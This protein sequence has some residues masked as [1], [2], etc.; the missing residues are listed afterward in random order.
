MEIVMPKPIID[1]QVRLFELSEVLP[2]EGHRY[3]SEEL[4]PWAKR[5]IGRFPIPPFQRELCW[6]TEQNIDLIESV[7]LGFDIGTYMVNNWGMRGNE[8]S[9]VPLSDV[10]LDGQQRVNAICR[11]VNNEFQVFGAY[12]NDVALPDQRRFLRT[13]FTRKVVTCFNEEKLRIVYNKLNFSGVRHRED[14]RA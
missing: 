6:T 1:Y 4:Y 3:T 2:K 11:Y 10:L 12:F 8:Q 13:T 14:Q 5:F 7:Y 9:Y